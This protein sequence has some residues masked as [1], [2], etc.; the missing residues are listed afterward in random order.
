MPIMINLAIVYTQIN[1]TLH[2]IFSRFNT[3]FL[4]DNDLFCNII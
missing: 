3:G 2:I 4:D 1:I